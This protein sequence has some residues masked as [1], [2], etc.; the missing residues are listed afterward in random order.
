V[1]Y[2]KLRSLSMDLSRGRRVNGFGRRRN[3]LCGRNGLHG[4]WGRH[5]NLVDVK[6]RVHEGIGLLLVL[7]PHNCPNAERRTP[8]AERRTPN[9]ERRTPNAERRL[10][11]RSVRL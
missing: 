7:A 1:V 9:A 10:T 4:R 3:G 2:P 6:L 5:S 8:N 11:P